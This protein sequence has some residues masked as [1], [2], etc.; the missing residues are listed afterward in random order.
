MF[1]NHCFDNEP[2]KRWK[3][4]PRASKNALLPTKQ[5][6]RVTWATAELALDHPKAP[7]TVLLEIVLSNP[8]EKIVYER[9]AF[10]TRRRSF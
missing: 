1:R 10:E 3:H 4:Q 8:F 9:A 6:H 2:N 7:E 5:E